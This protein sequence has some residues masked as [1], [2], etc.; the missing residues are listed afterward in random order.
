MQPITMINRLGTVVNTEAAADLFATM[1]RSVEIER[2]RAEENTDGCTDS[3]PHAEAAVQRNLSDLCRELHG[4][5][6]DASLS[7]EEVRKLARRKKKAKEKPKGK[8]Q[9]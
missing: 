6:A 4:K 5:P 1:L 2:Q 8:S 3:K 7:R 9:E